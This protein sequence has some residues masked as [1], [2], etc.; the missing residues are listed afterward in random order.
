MNDL[1]A[2]AD[3]LVHSTGGVTCLEA[4][5]RG[6]PIIAYGAPRGHAPT[7]ARA[8]AA[9]GLLVDARSR[10]DLRIALAVDRERAGGVLAHP[11]TAADLVLAADARVTARARARVAR[12]VALAV[13]MTVLVLGIVSSDLTYPLVAEAFSLPE[14]RAV[15]QPGD[16]I[17]L[18]V[19][20][21]R[22]SLLAFAP[23]ARS[24]HLRGSIVT[25]ESLSRRQIAVL[26]AAGLEP[27][28]GITSGGIRSSLSQRAQL[29]AQAH[30]YRAGR[31]FYFIAPRDG[32]TI[33]DYLVAH[34]L[35]GIPLQ[36]SAVLGHVRGADLRPGEIVTAQLRSGTAAAEE[37]LRSWER[38]V[39]S[40]P[41]V[42]AVPAARRTV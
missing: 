42:S 35:G 9:L 30:A 37:L 29:S 11:D 34:H 14:T 15:A 32:F 2:A 36:A 19:S 41:A 18:V 25:S 16:A 39:G 5:A 1:L 10:A 24:H 40:V 4:L 33:A 21:D 23:I 12:P 28:P 8:M 27:I 6:C 38:L 22:D 3:V 17:S 13:A 31:H 7:L 26:R 20:G